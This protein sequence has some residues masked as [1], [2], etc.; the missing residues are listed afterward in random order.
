MIDAAR[1]SMSF[2]RRAFLGALAAP[3][4]AWPAIDPK[5]LPQI[6]WVILNVR[7]DDYLSGKVGGWRLCKPELQK[8]GWING[9]TVRIHFRSAEGDYTRLPEMIA[10][11]IALP[12]DALVPF[13]AA[14]SEAARQTRTIPIVSYLEWGRKGSLQSN[15]TGVNTSPSHSL[16]PKQLALLKEM[17]PSVSRVAVVYDARDEPAEPWIPEFLA[18]NAGVA[19]ALG[20]TLVPTAIRTFSSPQIDLEG[21]LKNGIQAALVFETVGF[22]LPEFQLPVHEWAKRRKIPVMHSQTNAAETGGLMAFGFGQA[23]AAARLVYCI[24]KVLRGTKPAD[25]PV[26]DPTSYD[27]IINLSAAKAIGLTIPASLRIQATRLIE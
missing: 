24:D 4:A 22:H 15:V 3:F 25:L 5:R 1:T 13:G 9:Q 11:L 21:A 2:T 6:G 23:Q 10:G 12:V 17:S 14:L 20:M 26:E 18:E 8:L 16:L 19:A 7:L 27:L